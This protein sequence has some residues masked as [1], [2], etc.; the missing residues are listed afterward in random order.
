M[1]IDRRSSPKTSVSCNRLMPI[2]WEVDVGTKNW[3]V[4][5]HSISFINRLPNTFS[6]S[7]YLE[8][9]CTTVEPAA[10]MMK[11]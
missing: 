4:E 1:I 11:P 8:H 6:L 9:F 2:T 7:I 5:Y 3:E 10:T